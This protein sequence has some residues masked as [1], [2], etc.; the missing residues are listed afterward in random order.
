MRGQV[1][2][3]WACAVV[4][5]GLGCVSILGDFSVGSGATPGPSDAA[6]AEAGPT[7][8]GG[9]FDGSVAP[10]G[11]DAGVT[12]LIFVSSVTGNDQNPGTQALPLK[13]LTTAAQKAQE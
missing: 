5:G 1:L 9:N 2:T 12:G 8:D 11:G 7:P 6:P 3:A 4:L 13:R 10:D